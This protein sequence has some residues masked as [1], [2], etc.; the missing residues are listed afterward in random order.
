MGSRRGHDE[1]ILLV[2][3]WQEPQSGLLGHTLDSHSPIRSALNN[4]GSN[5]IVVACLV[6]V[7]SRTGVTKESIDQHASTAATIA[8]DHH[9]AGVMDRV[10][11]RCCNRPLL[12]SPITSAV[13]D[14][15]Q[16]SVAGDQLQ[17]VWHKRAIVLAGGLV[18]EMNASHIALATPRRFDTTR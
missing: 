12:K 5:G 3:D 18:Q 4:R 14:T 6:C 15:L 1:V 10:G 7:A 9:T 17:I 16:P 2:G 11:N 13:K 8:V